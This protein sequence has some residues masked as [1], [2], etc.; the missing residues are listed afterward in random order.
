MP[1]QVACIC[2]EILEAAPQF[3][4]PHLSCV[5]EM[6]AQGWWVLTASKAPPLLLVQFFFFCGGDGV[7]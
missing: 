6:H 5:L 7:G 4:G 1:G 3:W 2:P